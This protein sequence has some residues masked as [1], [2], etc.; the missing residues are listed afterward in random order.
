MGVFRR[1]LA[2]VAALVFATVLSGGRALG[3]ADPAATADAIRPALAFITVADGTTGS[4]VLAAVDGNRAFVVTAAHVFSTSRDRIRVYVGNDETVEERGTLVASDAAL[5][6]AVVAIPALPR[7]H[8]V[9]F[10]S[11]P[12]PNVAIYA[13]GYDQLGRSRFLHDQGLHETLARGVVQRAYANGH[14]G[15]TVRTEPGMSGGPVFDASGKVVGIVLGKQRETRET[16]EFE[17]AINVT[18]VLAKSGIPYLAEFTR[19]DDTVIDDMSRAYVP[20]ANVQNAERI[21][22]A[23]QVTGQIPNGNN[24]Y[25]N[26]DTMAIPVRNTVD[27]FVRDTLRSRSLPASWYGG[28]VESF[29]NAVRSAQAVGGLLVRVQA[30]VENA[31][32]LR[33]ALRISV[34]VG[35]MDGDGNVWGFGGASGEQART[36]LGFTASDVAAE[37]SSLAQRALIDVQGQLGDPT[38]GENFGRFGI[39]L[40]MGR[41]SAFVWLVKD[42]DVARVARIVRRGTAAHAGLQYNDTIVA[43]NGKPISAYEQPQIDD[44]LTRGERVDATVRGADG[45]NV[46]VPFVPRDIRAYLQAAPARP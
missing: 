45:R 39:P 15:M 11:P 42:G 37:A 12:S 44:L 8:G 32:L 2:G 27:G 30:R 31:G 26:L 29:A 28:Q 46:V 23:V 1:V 41:R 40:G 16:F 18:K 9:T 7:F 19:R 24:G 36:F 22:V 10:G 5:D 6:I 13:M 43:L 35:L 17:Q 4:G 25:L 34:D 33:S 38:A 21:A 20:L 14:I 3:A